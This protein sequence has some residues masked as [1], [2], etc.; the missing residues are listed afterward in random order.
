IGTYAEDRQPVIERFL[1]EV[2]KRLPDRRFLVAGPQYPASL[3]W[4]DNVEVIPHLPPDRHAAFYSSA[5]WQLNA[6]RADMVAA[7]WSPS[8]RI[9]EAG[10]VGAPV[11]SDSWP[12]IDEIF[13]PGRE[14]LLPGGTEEVVEIIATIPEERRRAI[15]E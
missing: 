9:F 1:V 4:P 13:A 14:L 2:A 5:S 6:T 8:V 10:A 3:D 11:I 12:G 15:G 7:G